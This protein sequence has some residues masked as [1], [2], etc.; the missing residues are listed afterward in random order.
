MELHAS[1]RHD[2]RHY[3]GSESIGPLDIRFDEELAPEDAMSPVASI[4]T[5]YRNHINTVRAV[6]EMNSLHLQ[7]HRRTSH[8]AIL[9]NNTTL[10]HL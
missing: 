4:W 5:G 2:T 3:A 6:R 7:P 10:K 8:T 9:Q 1:G